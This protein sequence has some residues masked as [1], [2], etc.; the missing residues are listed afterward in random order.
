MF[1]FY[2][3]DYSADVPIYSREVVLGSDVSDEDSSSSDCSNDHD[4]EVG[5]VAEP[6]DE[7]DTRVVMMVSG[8]R[9]RYGFPC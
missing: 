9:C 2:S 5:Q 4:N 7:G 8:I 3:I 6:D 1:L